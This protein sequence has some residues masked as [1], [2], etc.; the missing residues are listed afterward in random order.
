MCKDVVD[1]QEKS[2]IQ[3]NV[4]FLHKYFEKSEVKMAHIIFPHCL[5]NSEYNKVYKI[6]FLHVQCFLCLTFYLFLR[7]K[8]MCQ[9]IRLIHTKQK[10]NS[11]GRS[12][13]PSVNVLLLDSIHVRGWD[14]SS[15]HGEF[16]EWFW[17]SSLHYVRGYR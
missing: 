2:F 16:H 11:K 5:Y 4:E 17:P 8:D 6:H 14:F 10:E 13:P 3:H 1:R 7:N 9:L 15:H 12:F